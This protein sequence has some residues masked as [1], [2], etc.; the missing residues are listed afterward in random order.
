[1]RILLLSGVIWIGL[2]CLVGPV[3][4]RVIAFGTRDE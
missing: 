1:M 3:V 2:S 4:G